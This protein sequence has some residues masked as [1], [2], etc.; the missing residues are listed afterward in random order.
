MEWWSGGIPVHTQVQGTL[1]HDSSALLGH[2]G[3]RWSTLSARY[4]IFPCLVLEILLVRFA[5]TAVSHAVAVSGF[6]L[7]FTAYPCFPDLH[8]HL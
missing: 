1:L 6:L 2:A 8:K 5:T 7:Y 3:L 4:Q